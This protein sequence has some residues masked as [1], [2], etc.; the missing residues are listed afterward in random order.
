MPAKTEEACRV[1]GAA[2][3]HTF[4]H[5]L[6]GR[7]VDYF[8][9]DNCGY[10]QTETPGW[11]EEAYS[12][13]INKFDT[14]IIRRNKV[15]VGRVVMTLA[16]YR[17]MSGRVLDYAGGH[18]ILVRMLRDEG[19]DAFWSDK[20][21]ANLF[22]RGFEAVDRNYDLLTAFEVLEHLLHPV[23]DLNVMLNH[24]PTV[25]ASTE[26]APESGSPPMD[27]QYFG[28]EH[29][30][31]IGFFRRRTL[32]WIA[33]RCGVHHASVGGS[34]HLFSKKSV[35]ISWKPMQRLRWSWHLAARARLRQRTLEDFERLRKVD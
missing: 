29:G 3:H 20:Y 35:P 12:S 19:V 23:E 34:L 24:A 16:S 9:C 18:G 6:L 2:C 26:L 13:P 10:I 1:C 7:T 27:W 28:L 33:E 4:S 25:L 5:L 22:A 15:N 32:A 11:L 17:M 14:G 8:E 21:C 31:H 30:Q